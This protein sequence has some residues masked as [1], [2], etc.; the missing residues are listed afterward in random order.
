MSL[1]LR[2][3]RRL[4]TEILRISNMGDDEFRE[5]FRRTSSSDLGRIWAVVSNISFELG[6]FELGPFELGR[7]F[8]ETFYHS[9][10]SEALEDLDLAS[11]AKAL[12]YMSNQQRRL[13]MGKW[14]QD[15]RRNLVDQFIQWQDKEDTE[16]PDDMADQRVMTGQ[17]L[18]GQYPPVM[19]QC[20]RCRRPYPLWNIIVILNC[21]SHSCCKQC[22]E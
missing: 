5:Y 11:R 21:R 17:S 13:I 20:Y 19:N 10:V 12:K 6:P 4:D 15:G 18:P 3:I 16:W 14:F 8:P 22:D 9:D 7:R 1:I 2:H